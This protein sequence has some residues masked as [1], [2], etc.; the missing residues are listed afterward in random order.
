MHIAK[1]ALCRFRRAK[2]ADKATQTEARSV[3]QS[4]Q[5]G[6]FNM[7]DDAGVP[8]GH[9]TDTADTVAQHGAVRT[10]RKKLISRVE[11]ARMLT[12][13]GFPISPATLAKQAVTGG[14]PPYR[15]WNRRAV[16]ETDCLINW[17]NQQ[18][19]PELANT[20]QRH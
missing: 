6:R 13:A 4:R 1:S 18:L 19:G 15:I 12:D 9:S 2:V 17:A 11:A 10:E 14:G 7:K 8:D 20:A 16:Y 5:A 3:L